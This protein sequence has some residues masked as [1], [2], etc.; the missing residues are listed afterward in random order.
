MHDL[1]AGTQIVDSANSFAM[2]LKSLGADATAAVTL[3]NVQAFYLRPSELV[4]W[5]NAAQAGGAVL[6]SGSAQADAQGLLTLTSLQITAA[7]NPLA[8][9]CQTCAGPPPPRPP[10]NLH[11]LG[12]ST[13]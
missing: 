6:Q 13:P 9:T 1:G 10:R 4:S 2:S 11:I 5:T 8:L 7:G 3:L 12:Y